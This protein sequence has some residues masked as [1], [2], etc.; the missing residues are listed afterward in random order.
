VLSTR[1]GLS[2]CRGIFAK[3]HH[4]N[5]FRKQNPNGITHWFFAHNTIKITTNKRFI[6]YNN[7]LNYSLGEFG[8]FG[9]KVSFIAE[10]P[11]LIES[12]DRESRLIINRKYSGCTVD[13]QTG[14]PG[15]GGGLGG[16]VYRERVVKRL[17]FHVDINF[18]K[19]AAFPMIIH[20]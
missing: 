2:F 13:S 18:H 3:I 1:Q 17:R 10:N 6:S 14:Q 7:Q 5:S 16:L 19:W 20:H 8:N 15:M 4:K 12:N 11:H 9:S